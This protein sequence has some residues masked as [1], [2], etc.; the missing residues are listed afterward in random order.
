MWEMWSLKKEKNAIKNIKSKQFETM[1][2]YIV[3][4]APCSAIFFQ[5]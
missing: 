2:S 5:I 3:G 4:L 1:D